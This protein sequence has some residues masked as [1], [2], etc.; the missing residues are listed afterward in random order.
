M[1]PGRPLLA[2]LTAVASEPQDW[3]PSLDALLQV[4]DD[5]FWSEVAPLD[6]MASLVYSATFGSYYN[7]SMQ[8]ATIPGWE[9]GLTSNPEE[10][11]MR[12]LTFLRGKRGVVAFRGTDLGPDPVSSLADRCANQ[13]LSGR[14]AGEECGAFSRATLDYAAR[15]LEHVDSV[16]GAHPEVRWLY[17][18]HSLGALLSVVAATARG[19]LALNFACPGGASETLARQGLSTSSL[20]QG[21]VLTFFD[22]WDPVPAY[23][24][25]VLVGSSCIWHYEP[26]PSGCQACRADDSD[27]AS[28]EAC[29]AR[30]HIM[31]HYNDLVRNET[32][33][34]CS[35]T[36]KSR[37][38]RPWPTAVALTMALAAML[39]LALVWATVHRRHKPQG[40]EAPLEASL[41]P[42]QDSQ[43]TISE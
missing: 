41:Q 23:G 17:T 22:E 37:A 33:P 35:P 5:E 43:A 14:P 11:G 3:P 29:F 4:S 39:G 31:K 34:D 30:A 36:V 18:G 24:N 20:R 32:R 38:P 8:N 42:V 27:Q 9:R 25:G 10:G 12:A 40:P 21:Q 16:A 28:C 15:A 7:P 19:G 13:V 6:G 1:A 2:C 26:A